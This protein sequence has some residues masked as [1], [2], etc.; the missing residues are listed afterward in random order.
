MTTTNIVINGILPKYIIGNT[1]Q[2]H[3]D[4]CH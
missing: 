4:N 1:Y 2:Q 3:L